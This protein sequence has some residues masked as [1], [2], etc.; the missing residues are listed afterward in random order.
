MVSCFLGSLCPSIDP[1]WDSEGPFQIAWASFV[2]VHKNR[3]RLGRSDN[4][5]TAS[6]VACFASFVRLTAI[7][8]VVVNDDG[9]REGDNK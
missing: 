3:G 6:V 2:V 5:F 9:N 7:V 1:Q 4:V 8:V